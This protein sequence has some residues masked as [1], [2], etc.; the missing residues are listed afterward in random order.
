MASFAF[1]ETEGVC[2]VWVSFSDQWNILLNKHSY[3]KYSIL[4]QLLYALLVFKYHYKLNDVC[5]SWQDTKLYP[6][7]VIIFSASVLGQVLLPLV[8]SSK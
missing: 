2:M 6:Q 3:Y 1:T 4:L 7:I 5:L 8:E